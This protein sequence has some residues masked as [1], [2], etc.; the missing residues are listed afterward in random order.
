MKNNTYQ[1]TRLI[2]TT[3]VLAVVFLAVYSESY[4]LAAAGVLTGL[5]FLALIRSGKKIK[6]D[7]RELSVQEKA[8]RLTYKIYAPTLGISAFLLLFPSKSGLSVFRNGEWLFTETIGMVFAY[9]TLFLITIYAITYHFFN[10]QYGGGKS[11][12]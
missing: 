6:T 11:E 2:I 4:L 5:A 8:A 10:R 1:R 3:F 7:E 9:L 12:K